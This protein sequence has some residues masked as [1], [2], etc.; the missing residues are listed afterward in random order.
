MSGPKIEKA[1]ALDVSVVVPVKDEQDSLAELKSR[2]VSELEKL[3]KSFEIVFV[4]DGSSDD[5]GRVLKELREKDERVKV[6]DFTKNFGKSAAL[7]CGFEMA[8]GDSI[9]MMDGDLQDDPREIGRFLEKLDQGLDLVSGWK[10]RRQ[11]PWGRVFLSRVFN[12]TVRLISGVKLHDFNCGFKAFRR[13][14]VE[15]VRLYGELHRYLAVMVSHRGYKVGEI[16]VEHHRRRFGKSKYG[17]SRIPR[18]FFDLLTIIFIT[19]YSYQPLHLFGGAGSLLGILGLAA[20]AYL[21]VL[22]LMGARPI[23]SRPLFI[24]GVM[25][26]L[27]GLQMFSLGLI[28][29][30]LL[31]LNA[32]QEPPYIIRRTLK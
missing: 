3:G 17:L 14:A 32:H 25:L 26:L 6:F 22:W 30:L 1:G 29:E 13:E 28:G 2:V 19:Q 11:D 8:G 4:N 7:A 27:L 10:V 24:G 15:G 12:M 16:G 31:K 5:S 23:G 18:G 21:S 20:L 9:V